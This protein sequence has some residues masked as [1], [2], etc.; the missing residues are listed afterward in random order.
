MTVQQKIEA[1]SAWRA[2]KTVTIQFN[3]WKNFL[4]VAGCDGVF[5]LI[6][7]V[8]LGWRFGVSQW[9]VLVTHPA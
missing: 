3:D 2:A 4:I 7:F 1:F 8:V 9:T 5:L 6:M